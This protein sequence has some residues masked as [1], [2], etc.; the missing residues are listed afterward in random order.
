MV[1]RRDSRAVEAGG[2]PGSVVR[3]QRDECLVH[4]LSFVH[5]QDPEVVPLILEVLCLLF[6]LPNLETQRGAQSLVSWVIL[7]PVRFVSSV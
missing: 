5:S 1:G 2:L 4:F 6:S 3:N 7:D